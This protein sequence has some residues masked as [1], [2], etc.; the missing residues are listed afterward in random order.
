MNYDISIRR[1]LDFSADTNSAS[2]DID[3][4]WVNKDHED[5]LPIGLSATNEGIS[6]WIRHRTIP[7]NRAFV[8]TFL[9]RNGLNS[10]RPLASSIFAG[11]FH[12]TIATGSFT[13]E[14]KQPSPR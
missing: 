10:N 14:A 13:K 11:G 4:T 9:A 2:G 12:S 8:S 5:L 3:V 7:K 6:S 1:C